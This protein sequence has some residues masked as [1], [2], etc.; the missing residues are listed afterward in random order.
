MTA[1]VSLSNT[2]KK[3][4]INGIPVSV[5]GGIA[6]AGITIEPQGDRRVA[7]RGLF[8]DGVWIEINNKGHYRVVV[9]VMETSQQNTVLWV[10]LTQSLIL[11][12]FYEDGGA[13]VFSGKAMVMT[14]PT[15]MISPT[16][17]V[18]VFVLESFDFNGTLAGRVQ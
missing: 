2:N 8:G 18:H 6:E 14:A 10:A 11:S 7:V 1:N 15:M 4:L 12:L 9:S 17:V 5:T 3:L 16:V 13:T